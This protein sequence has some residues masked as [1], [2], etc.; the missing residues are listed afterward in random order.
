MQI[1]CQAHGAGL[2]YPVGLLL[3]AVFQY[4]SRYAD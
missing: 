4:G 2:A 1:V 3:A